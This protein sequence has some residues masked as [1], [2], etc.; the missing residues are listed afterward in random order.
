MEPIHIFYKELS[1]HENNIF[2]SNLAEKNK[3]EEVKF[4]R[5]REYAVAGLSINQDLDYKIIDVTDTDRLERISKL[6]QKLVKE[7][8]EPDH[9][10]RIRNEETIEKVIRFQRKA[11]TKHPRLKLTF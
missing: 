1:T 11:P 3:I 7:K 2:T 6:I 10:L 9:D 4:K 8:K 5:S